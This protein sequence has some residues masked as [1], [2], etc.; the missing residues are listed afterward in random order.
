MAK[1]DRLKAAAA[2]LREFAMAYPTAYEEFPWG[3]SAIKV[4]EKI[5]LALYREDTFLSLSVK[6]PITGKH[7]LTLPFASPTGYGLGKSGWVTARFEAGAEVPT[8]MLTGWID[9][10]FRAIAPKKLVA[11]LDETADGEAPDAVPPVKRPKLRKKRP[12]T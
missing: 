2:V 4:K 11:T 5:F 10:S 9:E 6:L 1:Q 3:H 12:S 7:A 8:D